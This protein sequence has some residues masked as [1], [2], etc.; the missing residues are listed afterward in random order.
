MIEYMANRTLPRWRVLGLPWPAPAWP[1]GRRDW[2]QEIRNCVEFPPP[3]RAPIRAHS[4]IAVRVRLEFVGD[5]VEWLDGTA[6]GWMGQWVHVA[7]EDNRV[8]DGHV[9]V[10]ALDVERQRGRLRR[11]APPQ[12]E[13]TDDARPR[14]RRR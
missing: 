4:P 9:W 13:T 1:G 5:G 2:T 11:A 3:E 10:D 6:T 12:N 7:I 14:P 8:R